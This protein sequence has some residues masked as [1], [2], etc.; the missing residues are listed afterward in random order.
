[1]L[2]TSVKAAIRSKQAAAQKANVSA[3]GMPKGWRAWLVAGRSL[4]QIPELK[5][6]TAEMCVNVN[7]KLSVISN[8]RERPEGGLLIPVCSCS[9]VWFELGSSQV[10]IILNF[11]SFPP[12]VMLRFSSSPITIK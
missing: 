5:G 11:N 2:R 12:S 1:M 4:V 3:A 10:G 8:A 7:E 9:E 6:R